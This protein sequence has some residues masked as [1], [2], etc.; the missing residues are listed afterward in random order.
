MANA[1]SQSAANHTRW[2]PPYHYF[3]VPVLLVYLCYTVWVLTKNLSW[4]T[5]LAAL[6]ALALFLL[7]WLARAM[8]LTAQNRIIR[9]EERLRMAR[10]FPADLQGRIEEL[11]TRQLVALRFASDGELVELTRKVLE[12]GITDQ[13][14]IKGMITT[15]RP[16]HL[17][18]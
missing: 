14:I 1:P 5:A 8:P 13:K 18:V 4:P 3:T 12:Q 6:V 16:D 17:R 10:L 2:L 9:L 11:S 15:W 7:S